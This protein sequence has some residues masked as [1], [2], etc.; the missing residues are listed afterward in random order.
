VRTLG[1]YRVLLYEDC[2]CRDPYFSHR[3]YPLVHEGRPGLDAPV[4]LADTPA[5]WREAVQMFLLFYREARDERG[6]HYFTVHVGPYHIASV[7][8]SS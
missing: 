8:E 7:R 2:D 1:R 5:F 4:F 6:P 3:R